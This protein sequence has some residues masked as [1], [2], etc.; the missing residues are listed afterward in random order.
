MGDN[1][2]GIERFEELIRAEHKVK[3]I[4]EYLR[5]EDDEYV[6]RSFLCII[7]GVNTEEKK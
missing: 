6:K 4:A 7:C 3:L 5:R 2:I 1:E